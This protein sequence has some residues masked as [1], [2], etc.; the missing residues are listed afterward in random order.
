M[1]GL[2]AATVLASLLLQPAI[3]QGV[4]FARGERVREKIVTLPNEP[5]RTG[6]TLTVVAR[7]GDAIEIRGTA[8]LV[9]GQP[10]TGFSAELIATAARSPRMPGR[11]QDGQYLVMG[12]SRDSLNNV[13]RKWGIYS[14]DALEPVVD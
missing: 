10:V 5:R 2:A 12:E 3:A 6:M 11:M 1:R 13:V 4:A 14:R 9:N 7:P 8:V